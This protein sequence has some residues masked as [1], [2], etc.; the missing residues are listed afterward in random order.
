MPPVV[1]EEGALEVARAQQIFGELLARGRNEDWAPVWKA[2]N[3]KALLTKPGLVSLLELGAVSD[4]GRKSE[5]A[6]KAVAALKNHPSPSL[7]WL[8][9]SIDIPP[10]PQSRSFWSGLSSSLGRFQALTF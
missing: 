3:L 4:E 7:P 9:A 5:T 8:T 1:D 6:A 2:T 10:S